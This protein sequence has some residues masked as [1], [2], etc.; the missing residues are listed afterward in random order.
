MSIKTPFFNEVNQNYLESR[1]TVKQRDEAVVGMTYNEVQ[2]SVNEMLI[3]LVGNDWREKAEIKPV[4]GAIMNIV[5]F[6]EK[7]HKINIIN[8]R[9]I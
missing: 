5:Q 1:I 2:R 8:R 9:E 3:K 7:A 6:V 4:I